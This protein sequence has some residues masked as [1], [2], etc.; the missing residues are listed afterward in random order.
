M[1]RTENRITRAYRLGYEHADAKQQQ[2]L[3]TAYIDDPLAT[4]AWWN[5]WK[6]RRK[7]HTMK[8]LAAK[9]TALKG[10]K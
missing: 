1:E 10:A 5:G 2:G 9:S 8:S 3:P 7:E 6:A 4:A